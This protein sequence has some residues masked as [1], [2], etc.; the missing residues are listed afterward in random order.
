MSGC[1]VL[2][3]VGTAYCDRHAKVDKAERDRV[4]DAERAPRP[5]RRW[6]GLKAW[7]IRRQQ[8][9]AHDPLCVMCPEWSRRASVIADHVEPHRGDYAKFWFGKLQGLCKPCH[10]I[11]KQREERRGGGKNLRAGG[12]RTGVD[13]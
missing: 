2:V 9:F 6:Y 11:R 12:Q 7:Q 4:V 10:D 3:E 13:R 8:C 1:R 5:Y